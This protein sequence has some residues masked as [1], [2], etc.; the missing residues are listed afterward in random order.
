[1]A[2]PTV[3]VTGAKGFTGAYLVPALEA[4][5]YCVHGL[6]ADTT[7][8]EREHRA[9]LHQI[10]EL[11]TLLEKIKPDYIIH[12]AA[13]SYVAHGHIADFY[14]TNLL[15]TLNLL[16]ATQ[17]VGITPKKI[18]LASSANIYGNPAV[19]RITET[20]TPKPMNHYGN[21]KLAMEQMAELWFDTFP[22]VITRPFNY[23][24]LGQSPNFLI[25]K[26]VQHFREQK[27]QISLGNL[28]VIRDVSDVHFVV[29]SY[30]RLLESEARSVAMNICSGV[31]YTIQA[32]L[33]IMQQLAGYH[34]TVE[35]AANLVR[36]NEI[37]KLIGC[38]QQLLA[39]IGDIPRPD[40]AAILSRMY[41]LETFTA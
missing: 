14:Q 31:G 20:E 13:I 35:T 17:D 6:V 9:D 26:I 5:D 34:I 16:Q 39:T 11:R 21:S 18:I 23:T 7:T 1:M 15:G 38:N 25:P 33:D 37:Q 36:K 30:I 27:T 3:L 12:L 32:M 24:G 8:S 28:D 2:Q 19:D 4:R 22:I 29:E 10:H 41:Q 40:L